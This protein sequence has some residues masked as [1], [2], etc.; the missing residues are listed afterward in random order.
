MADPESTEMKKTHLL[1]CVHEPSRIRIP[2]EVREA[3]LKLFPAP[4][5]LSATSDYARL[6]LGPEATADEIRAASS[7]LDQRLRRH[8]A[9]EAELAAAHAIQLESAEDRAAHDVAHPPLVLLKLRPT[10]HP[11]LDSAA[12]WLYVL[13]RELEAFLQERGEPVYRPSDL[14]RSDFAADHTPDPLLDGT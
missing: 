5:V 13:R 12:I 9:S 11:M 10:W 3:R 8:G 2:D 7:R 14:T 4:L 1:H 6:G